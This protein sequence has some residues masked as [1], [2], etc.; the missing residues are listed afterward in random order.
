MKRQH[1]LFMQIMHFQTFLT[2]P[3]KYQLFSSHAK[4]LFRQGIS[5][6]RKSTP[7]YQ[8]RIYH[9]WR[10]PQPKIIFLIGKIC[11][12]IPFSCQI[13]EDFNLGG[14]FKNYEGRKG[15]MGGQSNVYANKVN[16]LYLYTSF[17]YKGGVVGWSKKSKNLQTQ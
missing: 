6:F 5:D 3:P 13:V 10:A 15:L 7:L 9:L 1:L 8:N 4:G 12:L 2:P 17:L 11:V 14:A 16:D